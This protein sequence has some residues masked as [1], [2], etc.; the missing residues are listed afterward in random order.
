[1]SEVTPST[2]ASIASQHATPVVSDLPDRDFHIKPEEINYDIYLNKYLHLTSDPDTARQ[3]MSVLSYD[4]KSRADD[5][6]WAAAVKLYEDKV[7]FLP[8]EEA[9]LYINLCLTVHI[10][11]G[12]GHTNGR[13]SNNRIHKALLTRK[14][15]PAFVHAPVLCLLYGWKTTKT[16]KWFPEWE[17]KFMPFRYMP[18]LV[19]GITDLINQPDAMAGQMHGVKIAQKA[20]KDNLRAK[21][22]RNAI[23]LIEPIRHKRS[24]VPARH[25][26]PEAH[27]QEYDQD[28]VDWDPSPR[29]A[30]KRAR[31]AGFFDERDLPMENDASGTADTNDLNCDPRSGLRDSFTSGD[32]TSDT[33]VMEENTEFVIPREVVVTPPN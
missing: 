27:N 22:S 6:F 4:S 10:W 30:T 3:N 20:R 17:E 9:D 31:V 33:I 21:A 29:T 13:I 11:R 25:E 26:P 5:L 18:R 2:M 24:R 8:K 23:R 1:M 14:E 12:H 32:Q 15:T 28:Y 19:E 16:R 7:K